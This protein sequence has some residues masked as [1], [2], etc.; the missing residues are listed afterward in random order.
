MRLT[1]NI[2]YSKKAAMKSLYKIS[3]KGLSLSESK[4]APGKAPFHAIAICEKK[5][6]N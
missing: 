2:L 4:K 3:G 6:N 1:W 5:V